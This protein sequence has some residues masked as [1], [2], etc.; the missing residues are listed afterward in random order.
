MQAP[1]KKKTAEE[2]NNIHEIRTKPCD[3]YYS[4]CAN[5]L[6][7]GAILKVALVCMTHKQVKSNR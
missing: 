1:R 3:R 2:Q 7:L 4:S 5:R 6:S